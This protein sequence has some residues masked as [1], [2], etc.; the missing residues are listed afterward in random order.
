MKLI[1][2]LLSALI[3]S[4]SAFSFDFSGTLQ[5]DGIS[6]NFIL[7]SSGAAVQS[8]LPVMI[9]LHGDG[10]SGLG[11]KN[12]TNFD[13]IADANNFLAVYPSSTNQL[14]TGIWNKQID[15]NYAGE[16]ND[17]LFISD[18]IDHL[19]EMYEIDPNRVFVT[20]HSGGG[21]MAYHLAVALPNSIAAFAPVAASMYDQA[22]GT[23]L[24]DYLASG[25]FVKVPICHIH[26]DNDGVVSYPD[27]NFTPNAYQE[28]PLTG[29][30]PVTCGATTY[31]NADVSTIVAGVQRIPFCQDNA[32]SKEVVLIRLLGQGHGWPN[33]ANFNVEQFIWNFCNSYALNTGV[34]CSVSSIN[35]LNDLIQ[36]NVFPNPT[37]HSLTIE[38]FSESIEIQLVDMTGKIVSSQS[39]H[40]GANEMNV[41]Q[42]DAAMYLLKAIDPSGNV[43]VK[44]IIKE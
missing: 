29:F 23:F 13:A 39:G 33:V 43:I 10:G 25:G 1:Y 37:N 12:G 14:G 31:D 20:G 34:S 7:H 32:S 5:S 41:A 3:V 16:P 35:E 2:N 15:G 8:N 24:S 21:F 26:G 38:L 6:R 9:I 17:V 28:W 19:C 18:L 44:R 42:L 40:I 27:G 22:G 30:S 36:L 4:N 11:M